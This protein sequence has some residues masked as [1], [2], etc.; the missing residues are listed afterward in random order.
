MSFFLNSK[1]LLNWKTSLHTLAH[2]HTMQE[3]TSC[4][5]VCVCVSPG[6]GSVCKT[7]MGQKGPKPLN[8]RCSFGSTHAQ[9]CT[10][11]YKHA[12]THT[13]NDAVC[14]SKM[15]TVTFDYSLLDLNKSRA[16]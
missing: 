4:V 16:G 15:L 1:L 14:L 6:R 11:T 13:H 7:L 8:P 12:R 5:C 9:A 10:H 2:T 3:L